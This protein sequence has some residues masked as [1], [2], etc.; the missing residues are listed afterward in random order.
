MNKSLTIILMVA[1]Y[2]IIVS[3]C[4]IQQWESSFTVSS[5]GVNQPVKLGERLM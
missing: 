5:N 3:G 4:F 2:P 1:I